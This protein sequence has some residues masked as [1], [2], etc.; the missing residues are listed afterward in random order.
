MLLF[1]NTANIV[2][3]HLYCAGIKL[4]IMHETPPT[5]N[6]K[7]KTF[8]RPND[9]MANVAIIIA[10]TSISANKA[11]VVNVLPPRFDAC[12]ERP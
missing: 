4:G 7:N 5:A 10:G 9:C 2:V 12:S 8:F 1:P 6:R 11:N 3:I